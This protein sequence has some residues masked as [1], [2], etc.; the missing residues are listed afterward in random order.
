MF[1]RM[2][3]ETNLQAAK[4]FINNILESLP[5]NMYFY[6]IGASPHKDLLDISKINKRVKV[7]GYLD[8]PYPLIKGAIASVCPITMGGGIQNKIIESM[9]IGSIN[10]VSPLAAIP[11]DEKDNPG[12]IVANTNEE[13]SFY[14]KDIYT[15]KSKYEKNI[16]NGQSYARNHFSW[17]AYG[18]CHKSVLN[19]N[20]KEA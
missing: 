17:K 20:S 2:N 6:I 15:N 7:T 5:I 3:V 16:M 4:W 8:D 9:A 13:W 1:G 12:L 19:N 14:I 11:F 18:D 10:I